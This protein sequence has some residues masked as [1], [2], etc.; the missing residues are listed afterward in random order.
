[1]RGIAESRFLTFVGVAATILLLL[2]LAYLNSHGTGAE[3]CAIP[4]ETLKQEIVVD[5]HLQLPLL[6]TEPKESFRGGP[7]IDAL[8]IILMMVV[9]RK[10]AR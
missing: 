9:N 7:Y 8:Y 3:D 1:M 5:D 10:P 4:A 2:N 6:S